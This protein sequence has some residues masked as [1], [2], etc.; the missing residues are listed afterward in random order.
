MSDSAKSACMSAEESSACPAVVEG[1]LPF[2]CP[3]MLSPRS[4]Q[5]ERSVCMAVR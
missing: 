5:N 1:M 4:A 2:S 3:S